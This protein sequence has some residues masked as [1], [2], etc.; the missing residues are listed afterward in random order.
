MDW[1]TNCRYHADP[2]SL[3]GSKLCSCNCCQVKWPPDQLSVSP[4]PSMCRLQV[5]S[6]LWADPEGPCSDDAFEFWDDEGPACPRR[7]MASLKSIT[8]AHVRPELAACPDFDRLR[9]L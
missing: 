1:V 4:P 8:Y 9:L 7:T 3:C 2:C 5:L 6:I